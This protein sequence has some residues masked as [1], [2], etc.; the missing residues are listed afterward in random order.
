MLS[1]P[2]LARYAPIASAQLSP[3]QEVEKKYFEHSL[4]AICDG[5]GFELISTVSDCTVG[6]YAASSRFEKLNPISAWTWSWRTKRVASSTAT[7][8]FCRS[9]ST[10]TVV[11]RPPTRCS[12]GSSARRMPSRMSLPI[13]AGG[14]GRGGMNHGGGS[15]EGRHEAERELVGGLQ[16]RG[17][18]EADQCG[19]G[20]HFFLLLDLA[21]FDSW[22]AARSAPLRMASN[23]AHITV[24]WTSVL[25]VA[26]D[27]KPQ[28][29]PAITFSLPTAL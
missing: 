18:R 8:G 9:S 5:P 4:P 12:R 21:F 25:Y 20:F 3:C 24:G 22:R 17:E 11:G 28:S 15:G 26:C 27:E 1:T 6:G 23:L 13:T 2:L 7:S 14:P 10:R 16:R 29:A 19:G